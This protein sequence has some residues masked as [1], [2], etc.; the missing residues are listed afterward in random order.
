MASDAHSPQIGS[1]DSATHSASNILNLCKPQ[2]L[3][4]WIENHIRI[5]IIG[6]LQRL[7]EI[8]HCKH[9]KYLIQGKV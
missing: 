6:L 5:F 7:N 2:F 4:Q 9:V 8:V 3:Y 1:V